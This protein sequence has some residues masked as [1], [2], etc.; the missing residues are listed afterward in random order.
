MRTT[1]TIEPDVARR[2]KARMAAQ[3]LT[4]KDAVNQAL[5]TGLSAEPAPAKVQFRVEPHAFAFKAGID[6]DK[7]NQLAD[8]LEVEEFARKRRS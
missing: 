3:K 7:L 4:L 2:L 1:L 5:R 8:E 6:R